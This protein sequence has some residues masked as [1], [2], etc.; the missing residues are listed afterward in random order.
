MKLPVAI[1]SENDENLAA[2]GQQL[3]KTESFS[4]AKRIPRIRDA[5]SSINGIRGSALAILDLSG[6]PDEAYRVGQDI[7]SKLPNV[8]LIMTSSEN[9]SEVV[10]R[11]FRS[12]AEEYLKQP[13]DSLEISNTLERFAIKLQSEAEAEGASSSGRIITVCSG[14][15]GVGATTVA[16]NVAVGLATKVKSDKAACLADLDFQYGCVRSVLDIDVPYTIFDLAKNLKRIDPLFLEGSLA[17]HES[18]LR[19]LAEPTTLE[20]ASRIQPSHVDQIL[21]LL[22][23]SFDFLVLDGGR[24][25][26]ATT[27]LAFQKSHLILFVMAMDIPSLQTTHKALELFDKLHIPQSKIRLVVNRY[28]KS[29]LLKLDA[30]EKTLGVKPFWTLPEDGPLAAAAMNQGLSVW[31][32]KRRSPLAKAYRGLTTALGDALSNRPAKDVK[33]KQG[34]LARWF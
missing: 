31:E 11:A 20:E 29:R 3:E 6:N 25:I 21:D 27:S 14:K 32:A 4:V 10:L 13:F 12:G 23:S 34:L 8:H 18:G 15:G 28:V 9:G 17:K 30:I 2:L 24:R 22:V 33:K 7:R 19:V 1:I 5:V 16:V 26:D